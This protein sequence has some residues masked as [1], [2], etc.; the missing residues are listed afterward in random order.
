MTQV[1]MFDKKGRPVHPSEFMYK[2]N[3]LVVR[4]SF[5]PVTL[6]NMDMLQS[7]T[8][9]FKTEPDIEP[10]RT[11]VLVEM[12]LQ[13][14]G[15]ET[16]AV[17]EQDFLDRAKLM[18]YLGQMVMLSNCN[19]YKHLISY[20]MDYRIAKL[21]LVIG[22]RPLLDLV[23]VKYF[24]HKNGTLLTAF[25]DI[26]AQNVRMYVY[27]AQKE[28]SGELMTTRNLPVPDGM[29]HLY[30]H[31]IEQKHIVDMQSFNPEHLHIFSP[32]VLR[33][34]RNDEGEWD[35]FVPAKAAQYIREQFLFGFPCQNIEFEY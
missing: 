10:G 18:N 23:N 15:A 32:E 17:D 25:A 9:Q 2:Q 24:E 16:G 8:H 19:Q 5:R 7:A 20:L 31:M 1:T 29:R 3:V 22:A 13:N 26:C 6:V 12:T 34:L 4:G 27:P 14:L 35:K 28:G 30:Q 11:Q 33:L 21:G